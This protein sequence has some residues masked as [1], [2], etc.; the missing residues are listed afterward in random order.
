MIKTIKVM[1]IPNNKQKTKLFE[2]AGV[3]RFVYNW[4]IW[5]NE[6]CRKFGYPF[7]NDVDLRRVLTELKHENKK[8]EWLNDYSNDIIKQAVKDACGAYKNYFNGI[9]GH[10]KFKSKKKSKKSFYADTAKIKFTSTHVKLEKI[11]KSRKYSRRRLNWIRLAERDRIPINAKYYNP[12]ITF[13][14]LNW[15]VS[16]AVEVEAISEIPTNSGIG[17]DVGVK[18]FAV[19]SDGVVYSNINKNTSIKKVKK[20]QR[21]LQRKISKKYIKNKKG[22]RY[23]KTKNIVKSEKELLCLRRKS[24]NIRHNYLHHII[25]EIVKRKPSFIVVEGLN[26]SGMMKN[27]HLARAIQEQC[28]FWFY[29]QLEYKCKINNIEFVVADRYY[30]SSKLCSCCGYVKKDL[31][32]SER[33]YHCPSC[34]NTIDRD[35]QASVNLMRYKE[36]TA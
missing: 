33:M 3:A 19:C 24:S 7:M 18:D 31:K 28:F 10:P 8:F 23:C 5:Y 27:K 35:Y 4:T 30:P 21:R 1:L 14:G 29:D 2:C 16:V 11:E 17:I 9:S 26:V 36:L 20:K 34:G 25:S 12:R 6:T 15:W 13:D 32:L 22:G